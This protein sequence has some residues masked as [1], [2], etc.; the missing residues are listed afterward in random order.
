MTRMG[1]LAEKGVS[2]R[3]DPRAGLCWAFVHDVLV[4]R[5]L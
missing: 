2:G 4:L 5:A 1:G 3:Q